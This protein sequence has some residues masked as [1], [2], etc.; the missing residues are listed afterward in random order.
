MAYTLDPAHSSVEFAVKHMIIATTKGRFGKFDVDAYVDEQDLTKSR[1]TVTID[2]NSIDTRDEGRDTHLRSADF[3]DVA[4][5]P[6]LTFVTT[7][8]TGKG[9]DYKVTGDLTIRGVT[10]EVTLDGE[11]SG[12]VND[13]WGNTRFGISVSGKV[14]RKEWGLSWNAALEAGG[15]VVSDDVRLS[16]ELELTQAVAVPA[17]AAAAAR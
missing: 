4:N 5:H 11:V 14:N 13:P 12:P 16:V 17:A 15:F 7:K 3:F 10:K 8:L 1:A 2:A 9:S 6:T